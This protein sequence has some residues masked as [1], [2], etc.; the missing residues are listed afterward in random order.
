[1]IQDIL[2]FCVLVVFFFLLWILG[3]IGHE[4]FHGLACYLQKSKFKIRFWWNE[5]TISGKKIKLPSMICN[6]EGILKD[7]DMFYY[8]GGIGIGSLFTLVSLIFYFI[9]MPLFITLLLVGIANFFYGIY[10]GLYIRKIDLQIY[11]NWHYIVYLIA[12]GLGI[13]LVRKEI[14]DVILNWKLI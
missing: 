14:M 6:P 10:E 4:L 3:A 2:N 1:M 8:L 12:I 9:Y 7:Y 5:L 13:V 11:M